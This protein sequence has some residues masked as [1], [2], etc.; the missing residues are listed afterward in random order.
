[1][2]EITASI[3]ALSPSAEV[4]V[5][6]ITGQPSFAESLSESM[7][8][9]FFSLISLLLSATTTGMPS[10][11]SWVVKKRLLLRLVAST[12]LMIASGSEFLTY[13]L[14]TLSSLVNGDIE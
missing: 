5:V 8:V 12:I 13:S 4:A 9:F 6:L 11:R 7:S 1:M 10:S 2:F 14:V 3:T